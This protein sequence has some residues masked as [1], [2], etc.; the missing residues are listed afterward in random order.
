M[1]RL[2]PYMSWLG[3]WWGSVLIRDPQ[4]R[5]AIRAWILSLHLEGCHVITAR[6]H[7]P[8]LL[9]FYLDFIGGPGIA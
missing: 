4:E 5:Q 9:V 8:R 6:E 7:G 2:V 1:S 3:A